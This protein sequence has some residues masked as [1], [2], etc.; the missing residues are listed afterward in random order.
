MHRVDQLVSM[1]RV[2]F[3]LGRNNNLEAGHQEIAPQGTQF[4]RPLA[5]LRL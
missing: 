3:P 4:E 5:K 1:D 2:K